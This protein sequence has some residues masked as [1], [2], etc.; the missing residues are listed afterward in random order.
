VR[1]ESHVSALVFVYTHH[2]ERPYARATAH[3]GPPGLAAV[4]VWAGAFPAIKALFDHGMAAQDIA[5]LRYLV[6]GS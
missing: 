2:G 1:A 3:L 6:P 5:L 4:V